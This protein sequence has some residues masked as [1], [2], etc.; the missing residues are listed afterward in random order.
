MRASIAFVDKLGVLPAKVRI[1][2]RGSLAAT[3]VGHGTDRAALLG[4]VGYT[5]TTTSADVAPKP[6]EPI[7]STG[8]VTGPDGTVEYE[9]RFDP[10]PVAA[11]PNCLIFDAWDAEGNV[12]AEREDYYS[13]GGGFIQDRWE[14]EEHRDETGV[15]AAREI[16]SVPYPFDTLSLI[17]I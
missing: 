4:L 8:T 14:M 10:A 17:H 13:V 9:L 11:H 12:L 6:G 16:P 3:G 2:L 7:P 5:P 1:E 15:A